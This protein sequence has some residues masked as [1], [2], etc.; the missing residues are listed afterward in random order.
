MILKPGG[1]YRSQV[2]PTEV[3]VVRPAKDDVDLTCGGVPMV[4]MAEPVTDGPA[5]LPEHAEATTMG[6][7]YTDG[8]VEL[9]V[10]KAGAGALAVDGSR[11]VVKDAQPLPSSD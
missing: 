11:L 5:L 4:G 8:Q 6:K 3:V 1:R 7:R 9:L 10:T 2:D